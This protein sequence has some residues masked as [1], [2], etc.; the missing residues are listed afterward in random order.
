MIKAIFQSS[1]VKRNEHG[2]K[3]VY[4]FSDISCED[5]PIANRYVFDQLKCFKKFKPKKWD[6]FSF[7]A[8][9]DWNGGLKILR[10][11]QVE[12]MDLKHLAEG[13][14]YS[15]NKFLKESRVLTK[16]E[17]TNEKIAYIRI[18]TLFGEEI[19]RF[20]SLPFRLNSLHWF[21]HEDGQKFLKQ[22]KKIMD[23]QFELTYEEKS[24]ELED[25][26][27]GEDVEVKTGQGLMGF[28]K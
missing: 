8:T 28:M 23:S 6:V 3:P 16:D 13:Y 11:K 27:I 2:A 25:E 4:I 24:I 18:S 1:N 5:E 9:L 10:P 19:M 17:A 22:Q 12:K 20:I 26:K 15:I 14:E 7:D 21:L